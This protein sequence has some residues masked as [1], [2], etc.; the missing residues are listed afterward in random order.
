[1]IWYLDSYD[2]RFFHTRPNCPKMSTPRRGSRIIQ[3]DVAPGIRKHCNTCK[4][5]DREHGP[6]E[7]TQEEACP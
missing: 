7:P 1:M 2:A 3:A 5:D 6:Y 4:A